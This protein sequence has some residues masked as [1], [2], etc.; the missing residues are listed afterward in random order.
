MNDRDFIPKIEKQPEDWLPDGRDG[1]Y[2]KKDKEWPNLE[3]RLG[4]PR[5]LDHVYI[6]EVLDWVK[7]KFGDNPDDLSYFEAGC[8]HGNDLRA[9]KEKLGEKGRFFGVDMSVAEILHGIEYYQ[10][11]KKENPDEAK[12]MFAQGNLRNLKNVSL[13]NEEAQDFSEP[14]GIENEEFTLIYFEAILHG[15]GNGEKTYTAKKAAAQEML[16]ELYRICKAGGKFFGRAN[17]FGPTITKEAQFEL[18]RKTKEWRFIP[19]YGEL[20][21]MLT[22]AGFE[23]IKI[24][25]IPHEKAHKDPNKKEMLKI[26]FLASK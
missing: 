11:H 22:Q 9:I 26:S 5:I 14:S 20:E 15:L 8:G 17:T 7:E 12:K 18:L 24:A 2:V 25:T 4:M 6:K 10:K 1:D 3:K 16:N 13:W 23:D 21:E 19:G